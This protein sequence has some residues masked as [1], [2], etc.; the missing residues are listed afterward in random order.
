MVEASVKDSGRVSYTYDGFLG[1]VRKTE[2]SHNTTAPCA[3]SEIKYVLDRTLPYDNILMTEGTHNQNYVRGRE[4]ISASGKSSAYYLH[5]LHGSPV[6]VMS[7]GP[8][9]MPLSYDTFGAP[10]SANA[11]LFQPFGFAGYESETI[12]GMYYAQARYY[13]PVT[14]QMLSPDSNWN[15]GNMFYGE[16][17]ERLSHGVLKPQLHSMMQSMNLYSYC[18]NNPLLYVD[19]SGLAVWLIHGTGGDADTWTPDFREYVGKLFDESV[20]TGDW[21]GGNNKSSRQKGAEQLAQAILDF[22]RKNPNE[23]IRLVGH[24]HG[25]NVSIIIANILAKHGVK[26]ETLITIATPVREYKLDKGVEVGQHI[27]VYNT[28]DSVQIYGGRVWKGG[29]AG[30]KFPGAQNAKVYA[31]RCGPWGIFNKAVGNHSFMHSN[32]DVWR[33]FIESELNINRNR[34]NRC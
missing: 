19:P 23:P 9:G 15:P 34:R 21:E 3:A 24:S 17:P 6:R 13:D 14:A 33:D 12:T 1:R 7:N 5:D 31:Q 27:N 18:L 26:V 8:L 28:G 30:R 10:A 2:S 20:N 11:D 22:H 29:A 4:L 25:G 16:V 32:P